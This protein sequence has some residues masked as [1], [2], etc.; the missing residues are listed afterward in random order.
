MSTMPKREI[1]YRILE[2][3]NRIGLEAMV[4]QHIEDGWDLAGGVSVSACET[5]EFRFVNYAQAVIYKPKGE[6]I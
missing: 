2:S 3:T 5:L 1:E 6:S 4:N